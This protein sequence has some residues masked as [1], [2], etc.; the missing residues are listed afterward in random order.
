MKTPR[1]YVIAIAGG[2]GSGKTSIIN[3]L[4]EHFPSTQI[5]ALSQD[6]Y[7]LPIEKQPLDESGEV[8][9]D[10]PECIDWPLL[11]EHLTTFQ[12]G[13]SIS[14]TEYTFNNDARTAKQ[15]TIASAP[16][17]L[18]EGLFV[19][20]ETTLQPFIDFKV[21]IDVDEAEKLRRRLNRDSKER[22]YS[23]E[24]ILYQWNEH[25]SPAFFNFLMPNRAQCDLLID[26]N[27]SFKKGVEDLIEVIQQELKKSKPSLL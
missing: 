25:V 21:F 15:I 9:F 22:G 2:S 23:K 5:A 8:N 24:Q 6:D 4:K 10:L 14:K 11:E 19:F 3:A 1:P 17:L 13:N 18:I 12:L 26:N 7:Y 27:I 20:H 16:I